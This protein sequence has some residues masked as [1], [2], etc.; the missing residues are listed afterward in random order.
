L[1]ST[2]TQAD[3]FELE[4]ELLDVRTIARDVTD[5]YANVS[6]KHVLHVTVP[7]APVMV[8]ADPTRVFQVLE[9]LVRNAIKYSPAGSLIEIDVAEDDDSALLSVTDQGQGIPRESLHRIFE[10]FRR[11]SNVAVGIGLGLAITRRLVEAH[12]GVIDVASSVGQGSTFR[13]RLPLGRARSG[14][15]APTRDDSPVSWAENPT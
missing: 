12:G 15:P 5:Q 14:S 8:M 6:P 11:E 13:V 1:S 2:P 10:P 3:A 4:V 9:N 7:E